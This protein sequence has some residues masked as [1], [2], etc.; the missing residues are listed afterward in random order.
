MSILKTA[1]SPPKIKPYK[2]CLYGAPKIGKSYFAS[3]FPNHIF[4]NLE[5]GLDEIRNNGGKVVDRLKNFDG[6]K[7]MIQELL[8]DEHSYK[9]LIIDTGDKLDEYIKTEVASTFNK[10]TMEDVGFGHAPP[11][12]SRLWDYIIEGLEELRLKKDMNIIIISHAVIK[13]M[14]PPMGEPY[15]KIFPKFYGKDGKDNSIIDKINE[16]CDLIGYASQEIFYKNQKSG[17]SSVTKAVGGEVYLYC[18]S[19]N[20][21]YVGGGRIPMPKKI[22]LNYQAFKNAIDE[23]RGIKINNKKEEVK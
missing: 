2:F 23:G 11:H 17:M 14:N 1:N 4:M 22:P 15:D 13:K 10:E 12:L 6:V 9:N 21:T 8:T 7:Q 20:P 18:D 19:T 16:Y 3:Q 5:D